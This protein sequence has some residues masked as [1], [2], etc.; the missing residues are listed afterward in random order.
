MQLWDDKESIEAPTLLLKYHVLT[1]ETLFLDV[2]PERSVVMNNLK[3]TIA[4]L[5]KIAPQRP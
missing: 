4:I 1:H 5:I 3:L 2:S